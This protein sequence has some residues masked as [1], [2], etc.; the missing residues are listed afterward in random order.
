MDN[1]N[2]LI[3]EDDQ[4]QIQMFRDVIKEFQ[5]D[6]G[7][8]IS[9]TIAENYADAI[10]VINTTQYDGAVIDLK[11]DT[12]T[13]D[14]FKG[15]ELITII[16]DFVRCPV[17]VF[18]ANHENVAEKT[19]VIKVMDRTEPFLD[20]LSTFKRIMNSGLIDIMK[21]SGIIEES[22]NQIYWNNIVPQISVWER[23][24]EEG[25]DTKNG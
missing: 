8:N 20:V 16:T 13:P 1:L 25:K 17:I 18:S 9:P 24:V 23:Y 11:L 5:E 6:E 12:T 19:K 10:K 15:N 4:D 2:L 21:R 3:V 7:I 22:L 14:V